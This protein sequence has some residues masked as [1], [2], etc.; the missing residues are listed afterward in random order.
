MDKDNKPVIDRT[1]TGVVKSTKMNNTIIVA[2]TTMTRHPLYKK[3]VKHTSRFAVHYEGHEIVVGD[4]VRI[5]QTK[6]ISKT[7]HYKVVEKVS[8]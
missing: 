2:V 1:V 8:K 4:K 5:M 3:A 6:P 7:K